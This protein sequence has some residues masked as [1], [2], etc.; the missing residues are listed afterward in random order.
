MVEAL[1]WEEQKSGRQVNYIFRAM[2]TERVRNLSDKSQSSQD[3][4]W[5]EDVRKE[6]ARNDGNGQA[7]ECWFIA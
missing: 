4:S 1:W 7:P 5:F 3:Q 6:Q 2:I